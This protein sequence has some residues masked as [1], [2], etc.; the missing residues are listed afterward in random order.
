MRGRALGLA[1]LLAAL[2]GRS[3]GAAVPLAELL[4][5]VPL[6]PALR[7]E[8]TRRCGQDHLCAG[9]LLT[10][11]EPRRFRLEPA[12]PY[13][14][15]RIRW[16][17][18]QP[19]LVR[20]Q[21]LGDGRVLVALRR[22]G[23]TL[24]RE[25]AAAD[26]AGRRVVLDLR[27]HDG[28]DLRRALRLVAR[29]IGPAQARVVIQQSD[30]RVIQLAADHPASIPRFE[31][32]AVLVDGATASSAE[33]VAALLVRAGA[34][35]CGAPSRGKDWIEAV[36]PLA[37]GWRLRVVTG[38]LRLPRG[39]ALAPLRPKMDATAC[40]RPTARRSPA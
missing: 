29:L 18:H 26:L 13:D 28:G 36:Y 5:D 19:S 30:G 7:A 4:T 21:E 39:E 34:R 31:V 3:A 37:Q 38:W 33:V 20:R 12:P 2:A 27:G 17:V 10:V 11:R 22:F 16:V 1:L 40:L 14:T 35:L 9:R 23:R 24:W 6:T 32:E 15:D 25:L 8:L